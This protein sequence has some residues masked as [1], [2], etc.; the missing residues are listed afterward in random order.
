MA[1]ASL[2]RHAFLQWFG[3]TAVWG[4][5]PHT[6]H[7]GR[8]PSS[9]AFQD[10]PP[11]CR[12]SSHSRAVRLP[13]LVLPG[14]PGTHRLGQERGVVLPSSLSRARRALGSAWHG[15]G[16]P[17]SLGSGA[18]DHRW[19]HS[20]TNSWWRNSAVSLETSSSRY[21]GLNPP[22]LPSALYLRGCSAQSPGER[23]PG[24][25]VLAGAGRGVS[26]TT[27]VPAERVR[28]SQPPGT[29]HHGHELLICVHG[30]THATI[31]VLELSQRDLGADGL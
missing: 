2:G 15:E 31:V 23:G 9:A 20:P 28:C 25:G 4:P 14:F 30:G 13:T 16:G 19:N 3:L 21:S 17:F 12:T 6:P 22:A 1:S 29:G 7:L 24:S 26:Y 8:G 5:L 27:V 10:W 18:S 11:Q